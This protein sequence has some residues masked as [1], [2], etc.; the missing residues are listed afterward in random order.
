MCALRSGQSWLGPPRLMVLRNSRTTRQKADPRPI[1]RRLRTLIRSLVGSICPPGLHVVHP[2]FGRAWVSGHHPRTVFTRV[3]RESRLHLLGGSAACG[4]SV[5]GILAWMTGT[6]GLMIEP[7]TDWWLWVA[8][9]FS[10]AMHVLVS[11]QCDLIPSSAGAGP[12]L[13]VQARC[14][15]IRQPDAE[16]REGAGLAG[17]AAGR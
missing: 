4:S 14:R 7:L 11:E 6:D 10:V 5:G 1:V 16:G 2:T 9:R 8:P 13:R 12:A 17:T 3:T 15:R